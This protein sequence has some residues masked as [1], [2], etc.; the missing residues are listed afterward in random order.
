MDEAVSAAYGWSVLDLEHGFHEV[1]YLPENDRI[2][3]TI[4]E[5]ARKEVLKRLLKLNHEIHEEEVEKGLWKEKKG[6]VSGRVEKRDNNTKD[7]F[8][9]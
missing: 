3:Y 4:S 8:E 1:E 7:L 2:R 6:K 9:G 5:V